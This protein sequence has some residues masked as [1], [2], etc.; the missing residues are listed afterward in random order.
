M[1]NERNTN[2]AIFVSPEALMP[3]LLW[4]APISSSDQADP[5]DRHTPQ[6]EMVGTEQDAHLERVQWV[7]V[8]VVHPVHVD[9]V[10]L[11]QVGGEGQEEALLTAVGQAEAGPVI[12]GGKALSTL[13][14]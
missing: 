14:L 10:H 1:K 11:A 9:D 6:E 12:E 13:T 7:E 5:P 2:K 8:V 3:P 4:P